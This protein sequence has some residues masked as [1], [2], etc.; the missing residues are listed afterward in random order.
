MVEN[1]LLGIKSRAIYESPAGAILHLAHAELE[2]LTLDRDTQHYKA[3][4]AAKYAELVY[5]GQWFSPLREALD[6]F[7]SSTQQAVTGAIRIRLHKGSAR[8][9]ARQPDAAL[10]DYGLTAHDGADRF[11]HPS[12]QGFAY[13][14]SMPLRIRARVRA[15]DARPYPPPSHVHR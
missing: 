1:S 6:A 13:V 5:Y 12:G 10:Y 4:V 2:D 8:V 11:D 3:A 9:V 7:V 15:G 14:W